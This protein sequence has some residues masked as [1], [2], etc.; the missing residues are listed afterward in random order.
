MELKAHPHHILRNNKTAAGA[1][2]DRLSTGM[3]QSFGIV[4]GR[5]AIVNPGRPL[6]FVA[7]DSEAAIRIVRE[8]FEMIKSKLP[9]KC[10]IKFEKA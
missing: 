7:T 2:A 9:G 10:A 5:A 6:F 1:G 4:E 3:K 8:L